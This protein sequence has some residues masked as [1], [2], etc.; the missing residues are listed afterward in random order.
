[1]SGLGFILNAVSF[2]YGYRQDNKPEADM[3]RLYDEMTATKSKLTEL[4]V[5]LSH[6]AEGV[7]DLKQIMS[8]L[9]D[10][11]DRWAKNYDSGVI[12]THG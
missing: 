7:D 12:F 6:L 5:K 8:E 11:Q 4:D 1:M 3:Q 10:G 9:G 2:G